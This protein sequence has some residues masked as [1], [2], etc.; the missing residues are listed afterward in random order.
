M[1]RRLLFNAAFQ[2]GSP[3]RTLVRIPIQP[4]GHQVGS[5]NSETTKSDTN[6]DTS[7][8]I[9]PTNAVP[10]SWTHQCGYQCGY[11]NADTKKEIQCGPC[12][13]PWNRRC[14]ALIE[15]DVTEI[16]KA[17]VHTDRRTNTLTAL[18]ST[19]NGLTEAA[20]TRSSHCPPIRLPKIRLY[21]SATAP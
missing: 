17:M 12:N 21:V 10:P 5:T 15:I 16:I 7:I 6:A 9:G 20:S 8:Q 11:T 2:C 19:T 14:W 18:E 1:T 4:F 3:M 13:A